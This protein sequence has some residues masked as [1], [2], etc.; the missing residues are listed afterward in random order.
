[1]GTMTGSIIGGE[2]ASAR[3]EGLLDRFA[4]R[5]G[6]VELGEVADALGAAGLAM[7][8]LLLTL[9]AL[10]PLPGPFGILF[11]EL[12]ALIALQFLGGA[13]RLQL[14][15]AVRRR[16][17]SPATFPLLLSHGIPLIKRL[18]AWTT[19]RRMASL[20]GR[21]ARVLLSVP[22]LAMSLILAMPIPLGN[23][24]PAV[25]LIAISLGLVARDGGM[26]LIGLGVAVV[27]VG[28]TGVLV[29]IGAEIV[30]AITVALTA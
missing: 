17:L 24:L 29:T 11:G 3:L 10:V 28:W 16:T 18:E 30:E 13:R 7:A 27:A 19:P 5:D 21:Q 8:T 12:L 14:P 2:R 25:S 15:S 23:L 1:M 4:R 6:A 22:L 9:L 26:V 20:T